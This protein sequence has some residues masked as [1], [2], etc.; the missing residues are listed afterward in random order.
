M[1]YIQ[2]ARKNPN[3]LFNLLLN[4]MKKVEFD[5]SIDISSIEGANYFSNKLMEIS[6]LYMDFSTLLMAIRPLK[7]EANRDS[8]KLDYQDYIDKE[9]MVEDALKSLDIRYKAI[10]RCLTVREAN[11]KELYM[12]KE[13]T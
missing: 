7:R 2:L 10:N 1:T 4:K 12:L 3:D 8:T 11:N 6:A 9:M 13:I 5:N